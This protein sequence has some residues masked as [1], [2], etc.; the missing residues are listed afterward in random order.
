M[1][2]ELEDLYADMWARLNEDGLIYRQEA[3]G[4]FNL[5]IKAWSCVNYMESFGLFYHLA[6]SPFQVMVS[7]EPE[8]QEALL[9]RQNALSSSELWEKCAQVQDRIR[10]RGAGLLDILPI[11]TEIIPAPFDRPEAEHKDM[12]H[13][14]NANV[15]FI[16]RTAHDFLVAT[17]EGKRILGHDRFTPDD[18]CVQLAKSHLC[19]HL[20]SQSPSSQGDRVWGLGHVLW[21]LRH[22]LTENKGTGRRIQVGG[23]LEVFQSLW[24]SGDFSWDYWPEGSP[25]PRFAVILAQWPAFDWFTAEDFAVVCSR[26][27][28]LCYRCSPRYLGGA[29]PYANHGTTDVGGQPRPQPT[30]VL[31]CGGRHAEVLQKRSVFK[32]L[33]QYAFPTPGG[34]SAAREDLCWF[35]ISASDAQF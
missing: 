6:L 29:G 25:R 17:E 5:A 16:H 11:P 35:I 7:R 3:A 33:V 23:V 24:D 10:I 13:P 32:H 22:A 18:V 2:S 20:V 26:R 8:V 30:H 27:S 21:Y 1:P 19:Q 9:D 14:V 28:V 4:Y 12:W 31:L 15:Q 34:S